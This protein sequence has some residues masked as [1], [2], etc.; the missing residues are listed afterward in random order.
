MRLPLHRLITWLYKQAFPAK[1]LKKHGAKIGTGVEMFP[2]KS[3]GEPYLIEIGSDT[4]VS[5]GV[6]FFTHDA[7]IRVADKMGLHKA[8]GWRYGKIKIGNNC[9]VG[10]NSILFLNT[11]IGDNTVVGAGSVVTKSFGSGLI[12]G[13]NPAKVIGT[14][15]EYAKKHQNDDFTPLTGK[16]LKKYL[17]AQQN[18]DIDSPSK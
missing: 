17:L 9:F 18:M 5:Y 16:E 11:S 2:F 14:V 4:L 12:I 3:A 6:S 1:Y 15:E 10:A 7:V 8:N 13:G